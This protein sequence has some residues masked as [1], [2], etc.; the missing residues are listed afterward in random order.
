METLAQGIEFLGRHHG[1]FSSISR[2]SA[3]FTV[4]GAS[5]PEM[6]EK[7][8]HFGH[9]FRGEILPDMSQCVSLIHERMV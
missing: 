9:T 5:I 1:Y 2:N 8:E 3:H 4:L 6:F 7:C